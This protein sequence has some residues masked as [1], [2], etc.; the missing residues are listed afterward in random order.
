LTGLLFVLT[1]GTPS[2]HLPVDMGCGLGM[3]C[4]RRLRDWQQADV[5]ARLRMT[6]PLADPSI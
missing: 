2:E 4:W 6:C 3:S 5:W 1:T